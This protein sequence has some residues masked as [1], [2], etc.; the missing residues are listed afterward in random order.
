LLRIRRGAPND[1]RY[2]G[3]TPA[4]YACFALFAYA[5]WRLRA[6]RPFAEDRSAHVV[7]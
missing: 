7:A 1:A 6:E 5:I 3:L 2:P 4:Q